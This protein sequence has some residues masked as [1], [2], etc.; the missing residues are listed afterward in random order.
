MDAGAIGYYSGLNI[1]DF[2]RLNDRHLA[3][4]VHSQGAAVDYFFEMK[5]RLAIFTS[6]RS[7][8]YQYI[9]EAEAII[10]DP[11]FNSYR[12]AKEW[13]NTAQ[14]PYFQRLYIRQND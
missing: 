4:D 6:E 1:L 12:F 2:G 8:I 11:R 14:F 13:A 9:P 5:P 7:D 3:K 10:A